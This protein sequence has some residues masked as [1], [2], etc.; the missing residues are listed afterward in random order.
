MRFAWTN[1]MFWQPEFEVYYYYYLVESSYLPIDQVWGPAAGGRPVLL[2]REIDTRRRLWLWF[3]G[4]FLEL[5]SL[6]LPLRCLFIRITDSLLLHYKSCSK[7]ILICNE[8]SNN[9][10]FYMQPSWLHVLWYWLLTCTVSPAF[11]FVSRFR[12]F[13]CVKRKARLHILTSWLWRKVS[14]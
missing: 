13:L 12:S 6:H 9:T 14:G 3:G 11:A 7:W 8:N 5:L 2:R 10:N 1:I 4:V